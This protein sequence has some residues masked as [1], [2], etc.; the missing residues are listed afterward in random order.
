MVGTK[1]EQISA[2][3]G[4]LVDSMNKE[5]H[6]RGANTLQLEGPHEE[7]I[8]VP[9]VKA[10]LRWIIMRQSTAKKFPLNPHVTVKYYSTINSYSCFAPHI[11]ESANLDDVKRHI[12]G[13]FIPEF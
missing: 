4:D 1:K 6:W 5:K 7:G 8:E 13:Y 2:E 10:T 12:R 3:L 11:K 9:G